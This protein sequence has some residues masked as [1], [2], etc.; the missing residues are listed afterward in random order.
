MCRL[1]QVR[2]NVASSGG[3][4]S[5]D[6]TERLTGSSSVPGR[7]GAVQSTDFPA[8][9]N[10][11]HL[12]ASHLRY[13]A[14]RYPDAR[15]SHRERKRRQFGFTTRF[16]LIC[17]TLSAQSQPSSNPCGTR[18]QNTTPADHKLLTSCRNPPGHVIRETGLG[19]P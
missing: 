13:A 11:G 5:E 8:P 3:N 9:G 15:A 19:E 2:A 14:C 16:P 17:P 18:P 12:N 10:P 4:V 1:S 7:F 6:I